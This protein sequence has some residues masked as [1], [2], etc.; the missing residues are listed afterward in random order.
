MLYLSVAGTPTNFLAEST[1]ETQQ[2][3]PTAPS[4]ERFPY[5]MQIFG[6][7]PYETPAGSTAGLVQVANG[8]GW[9]ATTATV[10]ATA[11]VGPNAR[12]LGSAKVRGNARLLDY[13]IVEGSAVV[14]NNAVISGHALVRDTAVVKD[15]AKVRDYAMVIDNSVVA[16]YARILQHAEITAGSVISNWATVKGS[17]TTWHDNSVTT[18][19][20]AWNDAVLDGDFSTAQS[21]SNGFQFG[22]LEYNPGPLN[23]ITNRTAPRRL[24]ADY[25]FATPHDS[26]AKDSPGVT[27][28]YL[29]GS[30][31]WISF[32]GQRNGFLAFNGTNQFVI[33]DRS[34]SDLK[35]ITLTAWV[36]WSGGAAN[37]PVWYFGT[38]ATNCMFFT[39]DDGIGSA[40]FSITSG[41]VAQTLA[42]TNP[43]PVGVWTHVAVSLSNN[44][45]G[46][47]YINGA[48][49]AT[50]SVTIAPDQ[51]NAPNVNTNGQQNYL[52]RGAGNSLPFFRG[53]LDSV[54]VYTG[55]LMDS[56]IAA[57]QTPATLAAAG[58]LYVDLR[59]TN[60]AS[61]S[62]ATFS[63]WTN[64]GAGVGNFAKVSSTSYSTNV[65]STSIPGILFNGTS[66]Y[67]M[68][69]NTS[70]ADI[71]GASD[72]SFEVWV[73]NPSLASEETMVSLGD[74]SGTR[75]DCAF[76]FGNAAGWGAATHLNDDV[77]WGAKGIP[78]T[79]GWNHL[80]YTYDGNVTVKIY[81]DGQLWN[82]DT[83]A[84]QLVTPIGDPINI[85]CQRATGGGGL[86]G[87]FF[88]GYINAVR[89]WG[90][91]MTAGQVMTNYLFGPWL[92]NFPKAI[93][94]A[95]ISNA[96]LNAGMTLAVTNS[97]S[98]PN[99]PPLPVSFS[100][101]SAPAG[102]VI[103]ANSGIFSWRP[104]TAQANTTNLILVM[105]A[106]N[107][108][109]A[110][111]V[112]QS[113]SVVVRPLNPPT[114]NSVLMTSNGITLAVGGDY[115]PDYLV[116]VSTN[117]IFWQSIFT[118]VSP[119]PPF[120]WSDGQ[121]TNFSIRFYRILLGP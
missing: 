97:A 63:T 95:P 104:G 22:F 85:G 87:Q 58:T 84:G 1:D 88:S 108:T 48:N 117:L 61:S 82:T 55:A 13:A 105:A 39:P 45:T 64:F 54:R 77:P 86:P 19:A 12:V 40:K 28:G 62:L 106:N 47:L 109:P 94:F 89:V 46:R 7:T 100:L 3:Y 44:V 59:A 18:G 119:T 38:A 99:L 70:I 4:K 23:W 9:R 25:E 92:L 57:M 10:D 68:A 110:L 103:D 33:L 76:N 51:L 5:E 75:K 102:A 31:A 26:L 2:P 53:A 14:T 29:Q 20:Q 114:V 101:L 32:D 65:A 78:S 111:T 30:P 79:N 96:T 11:F 52:A 118:N 120:D 66:G 8:G 21:C 93:L 113:F 81:V 73:Y 98:D 37:Q 43:L 49:V 24:Y 71:T 16:N 90:S 112:T 34:L 17:A 107:A 36:K 74:R 41:G 27:D 35:E 50:G 80:V 6:A 56:E 121:A 115:G 69:T 60:A 15:Y 42:W 116:Q 67:Y 72:R 83:L 91:V